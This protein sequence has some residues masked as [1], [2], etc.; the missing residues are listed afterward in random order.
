MAKMFL[1]PL[2]HAALFVERGD[3]GFETG[4]VV[5]AAFGPDVLERNVADAA[6]GAAGPGRA[7]VGRILLSG[8]AVALAGRI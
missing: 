1:P 2:E 8:V 3:R 6:L 5:V 4:R 7:A